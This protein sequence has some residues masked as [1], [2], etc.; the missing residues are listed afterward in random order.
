M[1]ESKLKIDVRRNKILEQLR[2]E[3]KVSVSRLAADLGAT[4]VT[5]R[6][7]LTALE[8]DGY[9]VRM[10]GGAVASSRLQND[11][12]EPVA[13]AYLPQKQALATEIAGMISDGETLFFN[14]GTTTLHI[15]RALK[16]KR[17][18]NIVTNSLAIAMEL[19]NV[20]T[21]NVLLLGG[22]INASYG[23]TYGGDTQEQLSKYRADWAILSV[24]GV[25]ASGG[26]TTYHPEESILDRLMMASARKRLIA[27]TDS[28]IGKAGFSRV[29]DCDRDI[30]LVTVN[31]S[32]REA[33]QTL[34][35]QGVQIVKVG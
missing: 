30:L 27:A 20:A 32:D 29:C 31:T 24:D 1:A 10:Q 2:A 12:T 19:G 6:N 15:A 5:I 28:K 14:S 13:D 7:D 22:E 9:L 33:L 23:F 21:F 25:S 18:L 16:G 34:R 8:R 3:G 17:H 35:E 11:C 4:P 26:I